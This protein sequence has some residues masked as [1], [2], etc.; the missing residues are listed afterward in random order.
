MRCR[1]LRTAYRRAGGGRLVFNREDPAAVS[2]VLLP[3]GEC[4]W[5]LLRKAREMALRCTHEA[6]LHGAR[7]MFVTLTYSDANLPRGGTL[8]PEDAAAFLRRFRRAIEPHQV[9]YYLVGEYGERLGRPHYHALLFGHWCTDAYRWRKREENQYWRSPL[10]EDTWGLGAVEFSNVTSHSAA[11]C[12]RYAMKKIRG[13]GAEAHY[14][15]VD[16]ETGEVLQLHPE[17]ARASTRPAIGRRFVERYGE[18]VFSGDFAL[19]SARRKAP[20]PSYYYRV[21]A[22]SDPERVQR[23]RDAHAM[24]AFRVRADNTP[25]R[26]VVK[27]EVAYAGLA[28]RGKWCR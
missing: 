22:E 6:G 26:L 16:F 7:N 19:D 2:P 8:V 4:D 25:E 13:P 14:R 18:D 15:R 12:T 20:V 10:L 24:Q 27:E 1:N 3:C 5:C 23:A 11:Y 28:A 17:F 21:L 9:R